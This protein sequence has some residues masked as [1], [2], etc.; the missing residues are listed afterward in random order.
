MSIMKTQNN[1]YLRNLNRVEFIIT[2][3]CTGRCK[4]CSQGDHSSCDNVIDTD[5]A[6]KSLYSVAENYNIKSIMTFGGEPLI[7]ADRVYPIHRA[8]TELDIP[9]RQ[10]ITNGFFSRDAEYIYRVAYNLA[11]CGVN[12]LLLS[13]DAFHEESIPMLYVKLFAESLIK[14]GVPARL[15]PAWL[16]SREADNP[17]NIRT[18][19]ILS[20]FVSLG[21]PLGDGNIIFPKGNALKYL[22]EYI[23]PNVKDPY[24]DDPHDI[25]AVSI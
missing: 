11:E 6:V 13:V 4:H 21:L 10:L 19:E 25:R 1:Q 20:D 15:S 16:V 14:E 3:A 17:Y 12:D 23:D 2:Y 18:R 8:A 7:H 9:K 24:E 5:A 22:S